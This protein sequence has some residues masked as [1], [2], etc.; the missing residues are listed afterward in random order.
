MFERFTPCSKSTFFYKSCP[1]WA[2]LLPHGSLLDFLTVTYRYFGH[3]VFVYFKFCKFLLSLVPCWD[4]SRSTV[5]TILRQ[6]IA[7]DVALAARS[8][9]DR[10]QSGSA[11]VQSPQHLYTFVP[12]TPN[13]GSR[14]R[15]QPA[16]DHY[17]AVSIFHDDNICETRLPMLCSSC[18]KLATENC[19]Q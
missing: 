4:R 15:P 13:P 17:D 1:P 8:S 2:L 6:H 10:L 12:A 5:K 18:L 11:D 14:T 9:E 19:S 16:I 3:D 7:E